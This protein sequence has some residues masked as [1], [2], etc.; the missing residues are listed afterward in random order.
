MDDTA[1]A[2][3][4]RLARADADA[5]VDARGQGVAL[6]RGPGVHVVAD[7]F[8]TRA[9]RTLA[10][11]I[12]ADL[13]ETAASAVRAIHVRLGAADSE[14]DRAT[15]EAAEAQLAERLAVHRS[16]TPNRT[17]AAAHVARLR[18]LA[19]TFERA[20]RVHARTEEAARAR[21]GI[22]I[23]GRARGERAAGALLDRPRAPEAVARGDEVDLAASRPAGLQLHHLPPP[24][25]AAA[26]PRLADSALIAGGVLLLGVA[27]AGALLLTD[28]A[29]VVALGPILLGLVLAGL[30][31]QPA[32]AR[33]AW[34]GSRPP[35]DTPPA[36]PPTPVMIDAE[37]AAA[38]VSDQGA[39]PH[40]HSIGADAVAPPQP[41]RALRLPPPLAEESPGG[42]HGIDP[43]IE[44]HAVGTPGGDA[45]TDDA[46]V[47]AA[48]HV[49]DQARAAW[50]AAW[51]EFG[52]RAP[53]D[54]ISGGSLDAALADLEEHIVQG[55][56]APSD[57]LADSIEPG[58][59]ADE[60]GASLSPELA[61]SHDKLDE[62]L[63]SRSLDTVL[64]HE[65][66]PASAVIPP[67]VLVEPFA[68]VDE[69]QRQTMQRQLEALA[70]DHEVI[71]IVRG[72]ADGPVDV[73]R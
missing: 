63:A 62:L 56:R 26:H 44:S 72:Q 36:R 52:L 19:T 37:T 11:A 73:D 48:R 64:E 39:G 3:K 70:S 58:E 32:P 2:G 59:A 71:V 28:I 25:R 47:A 35:Y 10:A 69:H 42:M 53:L 31:R 17:L 43:P 67:L 57:G 14:A 27:L 1:D 60:S 7:A 16:E 21:L 6:E 18:Q 38:C 54:A 41:E 8:P 68:G 49:E 5:D 15:T 33:A 50:K 61:M 12:G 20:H 13:A 30:I 66:G 55:G 9:G 40:G 29:P 4:P 65:S 24:S 45:A 34:T 22:P 51:S 46:A 23:G